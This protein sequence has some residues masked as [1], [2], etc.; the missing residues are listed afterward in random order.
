MPLPIFLSHL[1]NVV[2]LIHEQNS[3]RD[4][5]SFV[6]IRFYFFLLHPARTPGALGARSIMAYFLIPA[7]S[8]H[9]TFELSGRAHGAVGAIAETGAGELSAGAL[10]YGF[11]ILPAILLAYWF[12]YFLLFY[13]IT[14][15][16]LLRLVVRILLTGS[17]R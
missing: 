6:L 7:R 16:S 2:C 8:V 9:P 17:L 14:D 10:C 15:I 13:S 11:F 12:T 5:R 1:L 4:I 3:L